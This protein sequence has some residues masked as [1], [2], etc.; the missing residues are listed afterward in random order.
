MR[1]FKLVINL[2][3][4]FLIVKMGGNNNPCSQ[5]NY[6]RGKLANEEHNTNGNIYASCHYLTKHCLNIENHTNKTIPLFVVAQSISNL[7]W[8]P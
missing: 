4:I 3:L 5:W 8:D 2:G 6:F 7:G 1:S